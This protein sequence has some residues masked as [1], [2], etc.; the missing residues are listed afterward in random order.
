[1]TQRKQNEAKV[2]CRVTNL[3]IVTTE[4]KKKVENR[5]VRKA[6]IFIINGEK[7]IILT[8]ILYKRAVASLVATGV[9]IMKDGSQKTS[10]VTTINISC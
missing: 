8:K 4:L 5:N 9:F 2:L 1:M 3:F 10:A 7:S 6:N